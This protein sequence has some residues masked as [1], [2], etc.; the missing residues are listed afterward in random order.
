V[1]GADLSPAETRLLQ[2]ISRDIAGFE[3]LS[4]RIVGNG[5]AVE[6]SQR[7]RLDELAGAIE[8]GIEQ[9]QRQSLQEIP[10]KLDTAA[11]L[12]RWIRG[13]TVVITAL[14]L[15]GGLVTALV[16][17]A[18]LSRPIRALVEASR[19]V[20][21]ADFSPGVP[22]QGGAELGEATRA[23]AA[24]AQLLAVSY[25]TLQEAR[26]EAD[27]ANQAK[28][29]FLA[30]M[31]H[32][33]RT[34]MNG[35]IGMT[36]LLLNTELTPEQRDY[37][38]TVQRSGETLLALI[39]DILDFSKIEAGN[40][41]LEPVPFVFRDQLA[42]TLKTVAARA[43]DKGLELA[44]SAEPGIPD[45]LLGDPGRLSQVWLNLV[46]NAIKFTER[47]EVA[48]D[49]E[50]DSQAGEEL[51]LHVVVRDTGIGIPPEKQRLPPSHASWMP[52]SCD[53][54]ASPTRAD[55]AL[56]DHPGPPFLAQTA[57]DADAPG[58]SAFVKR[59]FRA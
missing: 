3:E 48:V 23:F 38:E 30:M 41:E 47:G 36:G 46:G 25:R 43:H 7:E 40:L 26:E 16:V 5:G 50:M 52:G 13:G 12:I 49:V 34:P 53:A 20:A 24:M 27:R 28:S 51:I 2:G 18:W 1:T 29:E 31:S 59:E 17:S 35:V 15:A 37:A 57:G 9:L 39:N 33:I 55:R 21:A 45:V 19:R 44:Y 58:L 42:E 54:P 32:E 8:R 10:E 11:R 56:P 22:I 4:R 6:R 14:G